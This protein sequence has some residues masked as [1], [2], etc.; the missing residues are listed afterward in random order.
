MGIA[1]MS[2]FTLGEALRSG[3]LV[4]ILE[5]YTLEQNTFRMLWPSGK[6]MTPKLR[7]F[8][9]FV[10]EHV[11]L[12]KTSTTQHAADDVLSRY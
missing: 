1:Y 4:R 12:R 3:A 7:A 6:H 8:I 9:D 10:S 2:D 5:Q 11:P